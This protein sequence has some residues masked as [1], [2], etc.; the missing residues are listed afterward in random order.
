MWRVLSV[1]RVA[2]GDEN[3]FDT[4]HRESRQGS[5]SW[6][7]STGQ[8][9]KMYIFAVMVFV[10]LALFVLF[11]VMINY[12]EMATHVVVGTNQVLCGFAVLG[13]AT[14]G[15]L[16]SSIRCP[17]CRRRVAWSVVKV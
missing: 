17:H 1:T 4:G 2:S 14:C 8:V 12:P 15:W 3:R 7:R 11:I 9:W 13:V 16:L 6:L 10:D 5:P